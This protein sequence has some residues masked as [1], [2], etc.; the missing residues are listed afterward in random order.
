MN[1]TNFKTK[2]SQL[3]VTRTFNAPIDLVWRAWTEAELLDQWWA[4]SPWISRTKRMDFVEGGN[5]LYAMCGPDGE[6]HWGLT[7]YKSITP[8]S[9][10]AGED[11]FCDSE[12]V[13]NSELPVATF[14]NRFEEHSDTTFVVIITHYASEQHLQQVIQMGMKEGL[15]M[16][17]TNLDKLINQI[18]DKK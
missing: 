6:E 2:G 15:V 17:Y 13:V 10:F 8:T 7:I 5:R 12:G 9:G 11:C 1:N 14:Q 18:I 4:P 3:I 16:I